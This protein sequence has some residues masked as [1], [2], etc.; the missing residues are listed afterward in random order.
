MTAIMLTD[1]GGHYD[2]A[3][4]RRAGDCVEPSEGTHGQDVAGAVVSMVPPS[5][6]VPGRGADLLRTSTALSI[7][8]SG[9]SGKASPPNAS[10]PPMRQGPV[11]DKP[12]RTTSPGLAL[13]V[14]WAAMAPVLVEVAWPYPSC[15]RS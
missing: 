7:G 1:H 3:T 2:L 9:R 12:L 5:A 14:P 13:A 15:V 11:T 10:S 8:R 4:Q 6:T